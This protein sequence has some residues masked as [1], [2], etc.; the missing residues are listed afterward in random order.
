MEQSKANWCAG[1]KWG[2]QNPSVVLAGEYLPPPLDRLTLAHEFYRAGVLLPEM[3]E[4]AGD[5]ARRFGVRKCFCDP[6]EPR[7]IERLRK[8]R[9][10]AVAI[11]DEELA[12]INLISERLR[13]TREGKPGGLILSREC[14]NLVFEFQ[15]CHAPEGRGVQVPGLGQA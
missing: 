14:R 11:K 5:L 4:V 12:G 9:L 7:F 13:K 2:L 6:S 3:V 15:R 10:W 8:E 1:V